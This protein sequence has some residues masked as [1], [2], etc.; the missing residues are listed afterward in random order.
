MQTTSL[1]VDLR[2]VRLAC[3]VSSEVPA[4]IEAAIRHVSGCW[5]GLRSLL[6]PLDEDGGVDEWTRQ[7]IRVVRPDVVVD[8][9]A[10]DGSQGRVPAE[11]LVDPGAARWVKPENKHSWPAS[12]LMFP[13]AYR[14]VVEDGV[15][16]AVPV[17]SVEAELVPSGHG[18]VSPATLP[19]AM[20]GVPR[21]LALAAVGGLSTPAQ[22]REVAS[23]G[24]VLH[25]PGSAADLVLAQLR[26][27][28]L[29]A[30]SARH[31]IDVLDW[32][33]TPGTP[34]LAAS[35][36]V[37][38]VGD[39]SELGEAD[40]ARWVVRWWNERA[41]RPVIEDGLARL[42][43]LLPK[44]ALTDDRVRTAFATT[45]SEH[46]RSA[47]NVILR[48]APGITPGD[49]DEAVTHLGLTPFGG[50]PT[51]HAPP[52]APGNVTYWDENGSASGRLAEERWMR[53]RVTGTRDRLPTVLTAGDTT[54]LRYRPPITLDPAWSGPA[55]VRLSHPSL[56][57]PRLGGV[58]DRLPGLFARDAHWDGPGVAVLV[59]Y[60]AQVDLTVSIP[61]PAEIL[62]ACLTHDW[63]PAPYTLGDKGRHVEGLLRA[64][65][66]AA[67]P[68]DVLTRR[69]VAAIADRLTP[70]PGRDLTN[71][72]KRLEKKAGVSP[73]DVLAA[74]GK[75][76]RPTSAM[77]NDLY[78]CPAVKD[79]VTGD[80]DLAAVLEQLTRAGL[81]RHVVEVQCPV[82]GLA[83]TIALHEAVALP[84]CPGCGET[85]RY[86]IPTGA[87]AVRF[88]AT[89][90]LVRAYTN[91]SLVP[92]AAT[93]QLRARGAY[94]LPGVNLSVPV[95]EPHA[96]L[97]KTELG[98]DGVRD[99][100]L[101][102]WQGPVLFTA[103]AKTD[104]AAF[105]KETLTSALRLSAHIGA[106]VLYLCCPRAIDNATVTLAEELARPYGIRIDTMAGQ[107]LGH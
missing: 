44:D 19:A 59:Q 53:D 56:V 107:T 76:F 84:R 12:P 54:T 60:P 104:P 97:E 50:A 38:L 37:L 11:L 40:A 46:C 41:M 10:A 85:A 62:H 13:Y 81:L 95:P 51:D 103:E 23:T 34:V 100:D 82:C 1:T 8:H 9:T 65:H 106:Q 73:E 15:V 27:A 86:S 17:E 67:V 47:P 105:T 94:V 101:L 68:D 80:D 52:P 90:L 24:V 75:Q 88:E 61:E 7:A 72:L 18:L 77:F 6:V 43:L 20:G 35:A 26:G 16:A 91:G 29:L 30:A 3:L 22:V 28:S 64:V 92:A 69:V 39:L 32:Q 96:P 33:G 87:P 49:F 89:S 71:V 36:V 102:G 25:P 99:L 42:H 66:A 5:G 70:K 55:M 2:P 63:E 45:I 98:G 21:L 74:A 83:S 93:V 48:R 4:T 58:V 31:D 78:S 14:S 57:A 79:A